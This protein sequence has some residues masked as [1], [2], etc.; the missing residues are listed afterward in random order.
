MNIQ[1]LQQIYPQATIHSFSTDDEAYF[2]FSDHRQFLWLPKK[3]LTH[4]E[5]QLLQSL[6]TPHPIVH[7]TQEHPWYDALF[8][9][10][11][12]PVNEGVY[13][14]IQVEFSQLDEASAEAWNTELTSILP[15]L[16]DYFFVTKNYALLIE[17]YDDEALTLDELAGVFLALDGDFNTYTRIFV[18]S[19]FPYTEDFTRLLK[20]EEQLFSH[21]L[22]RDHDQKCYHLASASLTFF[23]EKAIKDSYLMR[24]LYYQWFIEEDLSDIIIH[25]WKNQGNVSSTA[26]DLFMHRNTLQYKLDKFQQ[27]THCN[28]KKMDD[29][30]LSYL[31]ISAFK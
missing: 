5:Q 12:P 13:R 26:K 16:V 7:K 18:G 3:D 27:A 9:H 10:Q 15:Q 28:L 25:L 20:E 30:F 19:F 23:M 21:E 2:V 6:I 11:N 14:M 8:Q 24:T 22:L 31:L 17:A 4:T 1:T 29:L